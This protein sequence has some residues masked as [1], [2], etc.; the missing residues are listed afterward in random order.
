[1]AGF[2]LNVVL[3]RGAAGLIPDQFRLL[4]AVGFCG[5]LHLQL[6]RQTLGTSELRR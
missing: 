4:V 2:G 3:Q 1:M 6:S 5:S